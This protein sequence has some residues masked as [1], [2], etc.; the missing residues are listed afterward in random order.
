MKVIIQTAIEKIEQIPGGKARFH[1]PTNNLKKLDGAIDLH[2]R[3]YHRKWPVEIKKQIVPAMVPQLKNQLDTITQVLII[4]E[5]ITPQ[6]R[7]ILKEANMAYVDGAGNM[8]INDD[9]LYIYIETNQ[10]ARTYPK[11]TTRAFTKAGLKVLYVLLRHPEYVNE[12]YRF[13]ADKAQV[14]LDT[15]NKTIKALQHEKYILL[16]DKNTYRWNNREQLFLKWANEYALTLKP[17][18]NYR[19]FNLV[20]QNLDWRNIKLPQGTYWG[21]ENAAEKW[22]NYLIANQWTLYTNNDFMKV[23]KELKLIPDR[24]GNVTVVEKFWNEEEAID[25]TDPILTYA[26]LLE[27]A[28]PRNIETAKMIFDEYIK[29]NL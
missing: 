10:A 17:K 26:D 25:Y 8:F 21:A 13:I 29:D 12:T 23:M 4:A 20:N 16:I 2:V 6:A 9:L 7:Q 27:N 11:T 1:A 15:I 22:S 3:N 24:N 18:L 14:G 19:K 28:N 5:Y